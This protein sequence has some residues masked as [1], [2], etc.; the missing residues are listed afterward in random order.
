METRTERFS[1]SLPTALYRELERDRK[2]RHSN[3]SEFVRTMWNYWK[4]SNR[5]AYRPSA[6]ERADLKR[7]R[8]E[9]ERGEFYTLDE[10]FRAVESQPSKKA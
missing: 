7:A 8:A 9:I 1:V 4:A 10:M 3:R 5:P 2:K 6:A